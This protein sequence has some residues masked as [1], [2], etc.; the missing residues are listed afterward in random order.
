MPG[1]GSPRRPPPGHQ[2][3]SASRW[4]VF[5]AVSVIRT[6]G[7]VI[8]LGDVARDVHLCPWN[9]ESPGLA[10]ASARSTTGPTGLP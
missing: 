8:Q 1:G 2:T 3:V 5:K 10:G 4:L 7:Q 9:S 6:A